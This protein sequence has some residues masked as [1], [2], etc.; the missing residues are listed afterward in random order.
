MKTFIKSI[1]IAMIICVL[2]TFLPF[3]AECKAISTEVFRL[4]VL[5]NSDSQQDQA[6]KLKVRDAVLKYTN[7]LYESAQSKQDAIVKTSKNLQ[8]IANIA[9]QTV[10]DNGYNYS[11]NVQIT[12]MYFNTRYYD[13]I[14]MPS[15]FYDALRITIGSGKGHNWWCVMY[16]SLCVGAAT[17]YDALKENVT[18]NQY[19]ILNS[20]GKYEFK[21]KV[22]EYFEQIKDF[23]ANK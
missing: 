4:H 20:S 22:V 2:F 3:E 1:S 12:N 8:Q 7:N 21:F 13:D 11:V 17:N 5:A 9:Q 23:F 6:L 14:T 15:G 10:Y 19:E 18:G 16:P